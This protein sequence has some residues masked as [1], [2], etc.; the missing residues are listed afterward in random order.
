MHAHLAFQIKL[1]IQYS[2]VWRQ[3]LVRDSGALNHII[4]SLIRGTTPPKRRQGLKV[5][6]ALGT[7]QL[8]GL[9]RI[10]HSTE[11]PHVKPKCGSPL[12]ALSQP[13]GV[14][15]ISLLRI[16]LLRLLDSKL[17]GKFPMGMGNPPLNIEI[18][19]EPNPPKSRISVRRLAVAVR[20][21]GR[22]NKQHDNVNT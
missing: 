10:L 21:R 16:S 19:L 4:G 2:K 1:F 7:S 6:C 18:M 15:P 3:R 20:G 11:R 22:R 9:Y 13:C 8:Q 14:R 5:T 17:S 12:A